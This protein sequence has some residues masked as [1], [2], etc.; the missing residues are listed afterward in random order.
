M[1]ER[2]PQTP[3]D[4][5]RQP[6]FFNN[7]TLQGEATPKPRTAEASGV[8]STSH[9]L[10]DESTPW[11]PTRAEPSYF[12]N[13]QW[14]E[15]FGRSS[16]GQNFSKGTSLGLPLGS[17][18][19]TNFSSVDLGGSLHRAPTL[20]A[21]NNAGQREEM[22]QMQSSLGE[23]EDTPRESGSSGSGSGSSSDATSTSGSVTRTTHRGKHDMRLF[24]ESGVPLERIRLEQRKEARPYSYQELSEKAELEAKRKAASL[25]SSPE[26]WSPNPMS[27]VS[28]QEEQQDSEQARIARCHE[29]RRRLWRNHLHRT[30]SPSARPHFPH[31][32]ST[33]SNHTLSARVPATRGTRDVRTRKSD[34]DASKGSKKSSVASLDMKGDPLS[35]HPTTDSHASLRTSAT[36]GASD[37]S[38]STVSSSESPV[39]SAKPM[40]VVLPSGETQVQKPKRSFA[41]LF[42]KSLTGHREGARSTEAHRSSRPSSPK[43]S[44]LGGYFKWHSSTRLGRSNET[45]Q[46]K[47]GK[48]TEELGANEPS[49]IE[50]P[51]EV[52]DGEKYRP[53]LEKPSL[54]PTRRT[55]LGARSQHGIAQDSPR[56]PS[57][58]SFPATEAQ[59]VNTPPATEQPKAQKQYFDF[60]DASNASSQRDPPSSY[61]DSPKDRYAVMTPAGDVDKFRRREA[62]VMPMAPLFQ[63]RVDFEEQQATED[64]M[65]GP[66]ESQ[67]KPVRFAIDVPDHLVSS[68]LC[69][70][71]NKK[72]IGVRPICPLHGRKKSSAASSNTSRHF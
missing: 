33:E 68:P 35:Q 45:F 9:D 43:H 52:S 54:D 27:P 17:T 67:K 46:D 23:Y 70:L 28:D 19:R 32:T 50:L 14:Q 11:P 66:G 42:L 25:H 7:P 26:Q 55:F 44:G 30:P 16:N 49:S 22:P 62:S 53:L 51:I 21:E 59:K 64:E 56:Q 10:G 8:F 18:R 69:P 58:S 3:L 29:E 47:S 38:K 61:D 4:K 2:L 65:L 20:D 40:S 41:R 60:L 34:P 57:P 13:A 24:D 71:N 5:P 31:A 15:R 48:S 39:S 37:D 12:V 63:V 1:S 72:K 36:R 6:F